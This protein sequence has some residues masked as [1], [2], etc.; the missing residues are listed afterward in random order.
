LTPHIAK[1]FDDFSDNRLVPIPLAK[2]PIVL[3]G[4]VGLPFHKSATVADT[5]NA[6]LDWVSSLELSHSLENAASG[7]ADLDVLVRAKSIE[8]PGEILPELRNLFAHFFHFSVGHSAALA[9]GVP[10]C[11]V[12]VSATRCASLRAASICSS[13]AM[14][15]GLPKWRW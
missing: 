4:F 5:D 3:Q 1:I 15:R 12:A 13:L 10:A 6:Q 14:V 11:S 7:E 9:T 2:N 8:S